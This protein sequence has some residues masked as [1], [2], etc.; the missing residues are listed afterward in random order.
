MPTASTATP[1]SAEQS[2]LL[3]HAMA[4]MM[5]IALERFGGHLDAELSSARESVAAVRFEAAEASLTA[6]SAKQVAA[7]AARIIAQVDVSVRAHDSDL[8]ALTSRISELEKQMRLAPP[9]SSSS[10]ASSIHYEQRQLAIVGSLGW[11]EQLGT[12]VERVQSVLAEAGVDRATWHG[13]AP[14][15]PAGGLGSAAEIM[16]C[17]P[18]CPEYGSPSH[19]EPPEGVR[20]GQTGLAR[21]QKGQG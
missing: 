16:F 4:D 19:E 13:M 1:F 11:N 2:S 7:D 18:P 14:L 3:R 21:R 5:G 10:E 9:A 15:T 6:A 17:T 20:P 12:L 8:A